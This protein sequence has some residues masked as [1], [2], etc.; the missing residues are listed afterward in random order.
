MIDIPTLLILLSAADVILAAALA[1]GLGG[2][3]RDGLGAWTGALAARAAAFGLFAAGAAPQSGAIALACGLLALSMTLQAAALLAFNRRSFPAWGHSAVFAAVA[4][5]M[6]LLVTAPAP[7]LIFG[8]VIFGALQAMLAAIAS[9]LAAPGS[10]RAPRILMAGYLLGS[11]A[12]LARGLASA[13]VL[14]PLQPF[15]NPTGPQSLSFLVLYAVALVGTF[16][17]MA[18]HRDRSDAEAS[19][20]ATMDPLTGTYNRRT[21]LEIAERELA[22]A[23]R[24]GQA[25]SLIMVDIDGFRH[26]NEKYGER[27][28]DDVLQ[29]FAE[30][31]RTALRKED[32]LVRFG[33]AQFAVLLPEVPGPGAVVVA[34]RIRRFIAEDA[35]VVNGESIS[36]TASLGVSARLDEGPE[37]IDTL[38]GRAHSALGL[39]KERGR[40]RVV[41]LNLGRSMAA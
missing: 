6:Q 14:D 39:A 7:A 20:L 33:G 38:I 17:F 3:A 29:Q 31:L 9:Q 19:R 10:R 12:L 30:L 4:V 18:L 32:M 24:A 2:H 26:V 16:G 13:F 36:I 8:G 23:R 1:I 22:R 41:A 11:T 40:N 5:P 15:V 35:M 34:G 27:M 21:F 25:L 37:S 28:G